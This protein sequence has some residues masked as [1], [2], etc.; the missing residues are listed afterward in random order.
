MRY[1]SA[2]AAERRS[3]APARNT[4]KTMRNRRDKCI[5][6]LEPEHLNL[7]VLIGKRLSQ[8]W[9]L[10]KVDRPLRKMPVQLGPMPK[11]NHRRCKHQASK[12]HFCQRI[13]ESTWRPFYPLMRPSVMFEPDS[14]ATASQN[15]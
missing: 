14:P 1:A 6:I 11:R 7:G 10:L 8:S 9:I 4:E 15:R 12:P 2:A 5:N 3:A 13:E